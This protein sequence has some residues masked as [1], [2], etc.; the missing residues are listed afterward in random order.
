M[1]GKPGSSGRRP[2]F[3]HSDDTKRKIADSLRGTPLSE[4]RR[5]NIAQAKAMYDLDEKC[6][7]RFEELKANYPDQEEFFE[8]NEADLLFAMRDV[9]T[10]KELSDI[11]KNVENAVLR[12][13]EPY[14][15][16]SSSCYAAEDAMIALLDFKRYIQKLH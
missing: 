4:A 8:E 1:S 9:R 2:G 11:R 5:D 10:E 7:R 15:Y 14:Q 16:S 13:E 3:K 12:P 6:V